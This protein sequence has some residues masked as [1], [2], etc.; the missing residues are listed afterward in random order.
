MFHCICV[1]FS[2]A[3]TFGLVV[4]VA[5]LLPVSRPNSFFLDQSEPLNTYCW[6][7]S[8]CCEQCSRS[9]QSTHSTWSLSSCLSFCFC[10]WCFSG[11]ALIFLFFLILLPIVYSVIIHM[12]T[13]HSLANDQQAAPWTL[14]KH[15]PVCVYNINSHINIHRLGAQLLE[16][17]WGRRSEGSQRGGDGR[18]KYLTAPVD[19][20]YLV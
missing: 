7:V 13:E 15:V 5:R 17:G 4:S 14:T 18:L 10:F 12:K 2:L 19:L 20:L 16:A 9:E 11:I 8:H 3:M 6:P 1:L